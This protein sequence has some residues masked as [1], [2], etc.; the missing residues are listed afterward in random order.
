MWRRKTTQPTTGNQS[1]EHISMI[2]A[3]ID[4]ELA[5]VAARQAN[6]VTRA[7]I[8]LAAAGVSLFATVTSDLGVS[9][10]PT[11]LSLL[12]ACL[13][14]AAVRY[15]KSDAEKID[16]AQI[17]ALLKATPVDAHW[18]L[19]DDK[20]TELQAARSDLSKKAGYLRW[21]TVALLTAWVSAVAI[22]F[23]SSLAA[24]WAC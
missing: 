8:V 10:I 14:L 2:S 7:S 21:A 6:A 3:E 9:A 19:I 16:L 4:R 1:I 15:W 17:K 13:S 12:S 23:L 24:A 5:D 11:L 20:Y 22:R 18:R